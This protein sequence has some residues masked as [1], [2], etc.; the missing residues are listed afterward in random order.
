M[1]SATALCENVP[2]QCLQTYYMASKR[3]QTT[4]KYKDRENQRGKECKREFREC[5]YRMRSPKQEKKGK[6]KERNRMKNPAA[7]TNHMDEY[8]Y[9][10]RAASDVERL[11]RTFTIKPHR[12]TFRQQYEI[13]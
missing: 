9:R 7:V 1:D 11:Y 6:R 10:A 12:S 4:N 5:E 2:Q 8:L 3:M 13:R